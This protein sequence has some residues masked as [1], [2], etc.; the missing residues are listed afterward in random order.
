MIKDDHFDTIII[1]GGAAGMMAAIWA[2]QNGEK[3]A[4]VEK[5]K[6][7]GKKLLL[8]GNGRCNITR[9]LFDVKEFIDRLGKN[10]KFL[11]S[12][13][14]VFGPRETKSF[15]ES[16]GLKL[17]TEKDGR[18]FPKS[19]K[20]RDVLDVLM[21]K[22]KKNGV[23]ILFDQKVLGFEIRD[24]KIE[25]VNVET[26]CHASLPRKAKI[27]ADNFILTTGGKSYPATGSAGDGY[28]WLRKMGHAVISPAPALVP[29]RISEPWIKELQGLSLKN[30][31]LKL[32]SNNRQTNIGSGEI[33]FTHFGLSG[34]AIINASKSIGEYFKLG[35]VFLEIGLFPALDPADLEEKLKVD[36]ESYKK[37]NL[38]TYLAEI[39]P[40]KLAIKIMELSDIEKER[41]IHSVSKLER[42]NL[43]KTIKGLRLTIDSLLDFHH[44][45]ITAGGVSLK[46]VDPKTMRSKIIDN[47]YLAGEI[48]DLDGPTGGYNLQIAW[49]TGRAAGISSRS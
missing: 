10:G 3:V 7:L 22:L 4:I 15:F 38:K 9:D 28:S 26:H 33:I 39:I 41:K 13:L 48:L 16:L 25:C 43:A 20:A 35:K 46:E 14:S 44:A 36:F 8:T 12:S 21:R 27:Y 24:K 23:K 5:N 11:F 42:N 6:T 19:D 47:L 34:P 37:K 40:A 49:T 31:G 45:M 30:V 2:S 17:K 18:V 1:G 29:V 32:I